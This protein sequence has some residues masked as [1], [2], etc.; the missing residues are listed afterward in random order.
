LLRINDPS[1]RGVDD[2]STEYTINVNG[3]DCD[4][5]SA[6]RIDNYPDGEPRR[7]FVGEQDQHRNRAGDGAGEPQHP[8]K[9]THRSSFPSPACPAPGGA[10]DQ[11]SFGSPNDGNAPTSCRNDCTYAM[12]GPCTR[13]GI[14]S[15]RDRRTNSVRIDGSSPRHGPALPD[16]RRTRVL[17]ATRTVRHLRVHTCAP[18]Y[19]WLTPTPP[20]PPPPP[21]P[22]RPEPRHRRQVRETATSPGGASGLRWGRDAATADLL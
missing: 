16:S 21:R 1:A 18:L 22:R 6:E 8:H 9:P 7:T 13:L 14:R 12:L 4:S 5:N 19:G 2:A 10:V 17:L 15:R 20:P 3:I 11:P